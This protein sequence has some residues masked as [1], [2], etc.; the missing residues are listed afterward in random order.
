MYSCGVLMMARGHYT[1]WTT[2]NL[3]GQR[4]KSRVKCYRSNGGGGLGGNVEVGWEGVWGTGPSRKRWLYHPRG[5]SGGRGRSHEGRGGRDRV[6]G[7]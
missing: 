6:K 1:D 2:A 5:K 3:Y 4:K 7:G